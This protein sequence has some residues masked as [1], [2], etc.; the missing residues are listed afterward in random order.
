MVAL[1]QTKHALILLTQNPSFSE[2]Q[3]EIL[4]W[5]RLEVDQKF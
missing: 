5:N 4:F 1:L 2:R 3:D